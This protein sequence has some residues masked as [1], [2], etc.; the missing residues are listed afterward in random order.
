MNLE[1]PFQTQDLY[2][3]AF[4]CSQGM[5][6]VGLAPA[7]PSKPKKFVLA[8]REDRED[9]VEAWISGATPAALS[10]KTYAGKLRMVKRVLYGE[11]DNA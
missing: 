6:L 9:L 11:K 2:L 1:R 4:L 5:T 7:E 3:A 8:D 10:A